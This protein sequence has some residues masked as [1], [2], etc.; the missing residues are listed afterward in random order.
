MARRIGALRDEKK[1]FSRRSPIPAGLPPRFLFFVCLTAQTPKRSS[2]QGVTAFVRGSLRLNLERKHLSA[3]KSVMQPFG[4]TIIFELLFP[5]QRNLRRRCPLPQ[6]ILPRDPDQFLIPSHFPP[7]EAIRKPIRH[8]TRP[9]PYCRRTRQWEKPTLGGYSS[10]FYAAVNS[11]RIQTF[12]CTEG[13]WVKR[14]SASLP[15]FTVPRLM[16]DIDRTG[17]LAGLITTPHRL[18][19]LFEMTNKACHVK[20]WQRSLCFWSEAIS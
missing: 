18:V 10:L 15:R 11:C 9:P 5:S 4:R 1:T 6:K 12:T 13:I 3:A 2:Q 16:S 7:I 8:P 14:G 19:S 20:Q 17:P